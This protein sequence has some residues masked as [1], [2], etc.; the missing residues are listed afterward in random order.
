M[1]RTKKGACAGSPWLCGYL[2]SGRPSPM[3]P[4]EAPVGSRIEELLY[5]LFCLQD[6]NDNGILEEAE[7]VRLNV[8][9]AVLHHGQ[10][11]DPGAV[12]AKYQRVFR[13]KLSASGEP[14]LY[15]TFRRYMLETLQGLDPD[16]QTQEL[17][18]EQFV[19]EASY[20]LGFLCYESI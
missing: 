16:A 17:I 2:C 4:E 8:V 7:L 18:M 11:V 3:A 15:E 6:L 19:R 9:I 14:V 5:E 13:T 12:C 1:G 10:A 20:A